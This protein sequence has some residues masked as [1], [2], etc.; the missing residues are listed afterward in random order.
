[1]KQM[2]N[3]IAKN[4]I[5]NAKHVKKTQVHVYLAIIPNSVLKPI[6]LKKLNLLLHSNPLKQFQV[7]MIKF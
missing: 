2:V 7:Q 4:V 1:M 5:F 3:Q 6:V